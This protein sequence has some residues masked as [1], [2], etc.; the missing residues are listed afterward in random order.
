VKKLIATGLCILICLVAFT[1]KK[2]IKTETFKVFGTCEQCKNRIEKTLTAFGVYKSNWVIETNL[3]TV[4]YDSIKFSKSKIQQKLALVGHDTEE[5]QTD[6]NTYNSLPLCCHYKRYVKPVLPSPDTIQIKQ[7]VNTA[8]LHTITGV[9]LEENKKGKMT[10]L[11]GATVRCLNSN[12]HSS[13]DSAGVFQLICSIP[14]D[15]V[16]SY[17]GF[18]TD[19]ITITSPNL[20]TVILKNAS[21]GNLSAVV[22]QSRTASTYVS[23]LSTF[24]TLNIGSKELAK[25]A[26]CNLSESFET[27][28]SVDVSYTDAVTGIKQIQLLGLAGNYT[29]LLTENTPEIKGLAGSYGL[30]FIP[31]PWI[32][33]IQ[34]TKGTG[35]VVTGYESIAGQINVEEKKPDKPD[36][37]FVNVYTNTIGRFETSIN[38][39]KKIND[40]WSTAFLTHANGVAAKNDNN[41]DRFLDIPLGRQFNIIN[42]WKYADIKG[43]I[44]QFSV[45]VL[46][47][48]RRAGDIDF[49]PA[50]D[51]LTAVKYG[52][53]I[54]VQQYAATGKLGYVFP[55]QKYK[56]IG[57][58]FSA[59][60]YKND[61]YY[62]L[63]KYAG[64][65]NSVYANLIY[66]SVIGNTAHKFR[67]GLSFANDRFNET[68]NAANY[69]RNEIVPGAFFEYTYTADKKF[70]AIAGLRF[71][72]HNQYGFIS[73]PRL[74]LKYDFA[75]KTNLR[76][77]V[78]S[79]FRVAN[80]FA[81]NAGMFVSARQ[82]YIINPTN[83]FGYGLDPEK[84]WNYGLNFIHN[85][86]I[87]NLPGSFSID[88][89]HTQFNNQTVVDLDNNPQKILFYNLAGKSFS[90]SIQGELNYEAAKKLELRLAYRWQDVKTNYT[91]GLLEK[92]LVAKHRAFINAA[93]E[94]KNHWKL[95]FTTQW[96]SKKR[97][98]DTGGNPPDKQ[99]GSYSPA[100]IQMS[101][102]VTKQI[103]GIWDLYVG[104]ENL[105]NYMQKKLIIAA[106]QP[107]SQYFDGS[108]IWGPVNGRIVYAGFR[109]KIK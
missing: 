59:A 50:T 58:I 12:H 51:K 56:S 6:E 16:V 13:A 108:I 73:T 45:K 68:F 42:R 2:N 18:K 79:G 62:G 63:T 109:F 69:K 82:Y 84:A 70:T 83:N 43:V 92:P 27:N 22:V 47:D 87:N 7:G 93:Y 67:T 95:D 1:Q 11:A 74:H 66:Q 15:I 36:K 91:E 78:G 31:G 76:L 90:N 77:S 80:I 4:S 103:D 49:N 105:T 30:T 25:A 44:A 101:G 61:S 98:P 52:A 34:V 8:Q 10:P 48:R 5:Y 23:S 38:F 29:Q 53:G 97:L 33:G 32:E 21:S 75:P 54:D 102:Q 64:K 60:N 26:C 24:N 37:L 100:F 20:I 89:Y 88:A 14:A 19:T 41:K 3:L 104:G 28:P 57:F 55:Q 107:F 81:E 40:K 65:Q 86:K 39:S 46:N 94:T 96:L 35:S 72:Y 106:S 85:F 71:D 9:I 99:L 17:V